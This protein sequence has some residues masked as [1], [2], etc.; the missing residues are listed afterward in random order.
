MADGSSNSIVNL[1]RISK[2]AEI[3]LRKISKAFGTVFEPYQLKRMAK[4]EV[5][6]SMTRAEGEIAVT[7][8]QRRAMRR[9]VNE[10]AIR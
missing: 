3:L 9:F 8:L 10:E 7:D 1:G 6:A 4:A 2:P 5:A